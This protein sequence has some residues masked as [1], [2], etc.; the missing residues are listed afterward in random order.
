MV[1][2]SG[3][4]ASTHPQ[5]KVVHQPAQHLHSSLG[6]SGLSSPRAN[7]EAEVAGSQR[8]S[9]TVE[10]DLQARKSQSASLTPDRN[11]AGGSNNS[12]GSAP[13]PTEL[14]SSVSQGTLRSHQISKSQRQAA[15]HRR[16]ASTDNGNGSSSP[17]DSSDATPPMERQS[18]STRSGFSFSSIAN[19]LRDENPGESLGEIRKRLASLEKE[20]ELVL[21]TRKLTEMEADK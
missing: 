16:F 3:C 11:F 13:L 8:S 2:R 9:T 5:S 7:S 6:S 15:F 18:P 17:D 20:K 14:G 12:R 4:N 10:P 21:L 19:R 1:F